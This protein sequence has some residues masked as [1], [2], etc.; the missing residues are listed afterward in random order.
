MSEAEVSESEKRLQRGREL[1]TVLA[2]RF[3]LDPNDSDLAEAFASLI[4]QYHRDRLIHD[5]K[6]DFARAR[7]AYRNLQDAIQTLRGALQSDA[8]D[9][10]FAIYWE[11]MRS[12]AKE[13]GESAASFGV[14][15]DVGAQFMADLNRSL[16]LLARTAD[17]RIEELKS[18][19]G[20]KADEALRGLVQGCALIWA[21][22][23]GRSFTLDHHD[24]APL[25]EAG[26]FVFA[27][28]GK[29]APEVSRTQ[30]LTAMR[31]V[32][33]DRRAATTHKN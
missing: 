22:K 9:L 31:A 14:H 17:F 24:G 16:D 19:K 12:C 33:A 11:R 21:D 1:L 32:I 8:L 27:I 15:P 4:A 5:E 10:D 20:R 30:T 25:T 6:P 3:Q 29:V 23:L 7:E 26:G 13:T 28:V 2:D 18:P